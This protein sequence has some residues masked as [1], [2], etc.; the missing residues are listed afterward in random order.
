METTEKTPESR[1]LL[2]EKTAE[3]EQFETQMH[4]GA[5]LHLRL[6]TKIAR[7]TKYKMRQEPVEQ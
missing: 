3:R 5:P 4:C 1:T 7:H 6:S 2:R